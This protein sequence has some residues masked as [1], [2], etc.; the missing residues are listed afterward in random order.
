MYIQEEEESGPEFVAD[1]EI[2]E[3]DLS[4]IEDWGSLK[5]EEDRGESFSSAVESETD[6]EERLVIGRKRTR[7]P[8][9]EI[10]YETELEPRAK[11]KA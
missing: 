8:V 10:E 1:D 6:E 2:E 5:M 4:D 7:K 9:L 11:L 3:S